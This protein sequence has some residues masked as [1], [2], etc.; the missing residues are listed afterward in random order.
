MCIVRRDCPPLSSLLLNL[1]VIT[2]YQAPPICLFVNRNMCV[3]MA[4]LAETSKLLESRTILDHDQDI[5]IGSLL[6][7]FLNLVTAMDTSIKRIDSL[8]GIVYIPQEYTSCSSDDVFRQFENEYLNFSVN[9]SNICLLGYS[10]SR[11]TAAENGVANLDLL[12][13]PRK[14]ISKDRG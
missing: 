9:Y 7:S 6:H 8:F 14:R 13:K 3:N 11:T 4:N 2:Y 12:N 1:H 5:N 10:N